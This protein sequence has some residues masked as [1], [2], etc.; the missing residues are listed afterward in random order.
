M[1]EAKRYID[2]YKYNRENILNNDQFFLQG[3]FKNNKFN[4]K[5]NNINQILDNYYSLPEGNQDFQGLNDYD[6]LN[7]LNNDKILNYNGNPFQSNDFNEL[8]QNDNIL[9]NFYI[10][11]SAPNKIINNEK[12]KYSE[13]NNYL[14]NRNN[15]EKGD[16]YINSD[17]NSINNVDNLYGNYPYNQNNFENSKIERDLITSQYNRN[18]ANNFFDENHLKFFDGFRFKEKEISVKIKEKTTDNNK[19]EIIREKFKN[20][21]Q[22]K[23]IRDNPCFNKGYYNKDLNFTGSGNFTNCYE[24]IENL[25]SKDDL[26]KVYSKLEK[27]NLITNTKIITNKTNNKHNFEIENGNKTNYLSEN[28]VYLDDQFKKFKFLFFEQNNEKRSWVFNK[29]MQYK[30]LKEKVKNICEIQYSRV[31]SELIQFK[32]K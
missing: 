22:D 7:Q 6:N 23:Q 27:N 5:A 8:K 25:I 16:V 14:S 30:I 3:N 1:S 29:K 15:I 9:N 4:D 28:Y 19:K 17:L 20:S 12:K 26:E 24:F 2:K 21:F 11:N 13:K 10:N 31:L 18:S 32:I